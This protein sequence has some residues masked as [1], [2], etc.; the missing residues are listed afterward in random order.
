MIAM[1]AAL[2]LVTVEN[3]SLPREQPPFAQALAERM[4]CRSSPRPEP[5]LRAMVRSGYIDFRR[6][7]SLDQVSC[8]RLKRRLDLT[9]AD[10]KTSVQVTWIC[11]WDWTKSREPKIM[12]EAPGTPPDP[13]ILLVVK[14]ASA[15]ADAWVRA[16]RSTKD[17]NVGSVLNNAHVAGPTHGVT[18][19]CSLL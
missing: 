16:N 8:F 18:I 6:D 4:R 10:A 19:K 9:A 11:A 14:D 12:P 7:A 2:A 13:F 5:I 17:V 1:A 3:S 15:R